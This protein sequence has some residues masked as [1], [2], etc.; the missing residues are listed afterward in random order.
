M[1]QSIGQANTKIGYKQTTYIQ[2]WNNGC[3]KH[4]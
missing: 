1:K 3:Y 4:E 2:N